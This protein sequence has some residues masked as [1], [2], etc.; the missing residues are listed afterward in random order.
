MRT[1]LVANDVTWD[2]KAVREQVLCADKDKERNKRDCEHYFH[3]L[4]H[5]LNSNWS[6]SHVVTYLSISL[7][8]LEYFSEIFVSFLILIPSLAPLSDGLSVE[9]EDV[10]KGIEQED[11][12]WSD[13][14][15]IQQ[16]RLRRCVKA[17]RHQSGLNH[18]QAVVDVLGVEHVP[19]FVAG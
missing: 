14:Y 19:V 13:R 5:S 18:D 1:V 12:V 15:R 7:G 11:H 16:D 17:V 6:S 4:V 10:K 3:T 9:D 2:R 8:V